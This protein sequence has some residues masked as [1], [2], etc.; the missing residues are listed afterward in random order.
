MHELFFLVFNIGI[1]NA[2]HSELN[3]LSCVTE[4]RHANLGMPN[5]G[6]ISFIG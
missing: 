1:E 4:F 6:K 3:I 2:V 5:L